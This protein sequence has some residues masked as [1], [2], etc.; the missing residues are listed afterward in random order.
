MVNKENVQDIYGLSAMQKGMLINYALDPSSV[1]YVEQFSFKIRGNVVPERM[2][3]ALKKVSQSYS[4]LRSIFSYKKTNQPRQVVLKKWDPQLIIKDFRNQENANEL[5]ETFKKEDKEKGFD[6]SK[7]VLI[8]GA[9][10][11]VEDQV[12]QFVL[13]F[14]HILMDGWSLSPI[15]RDII[16]YYSASSE[17]EIAK[18]RYPYKEYIRWYEKQ[19]TQEAADY[20]KKY[21]SDYEKSAVVPAL[22]DHTISGHDRHIFCLSS[23]I[24]EGMKELAKQM[25]VTIN[26]IFIVAWGILLQRYNYTTDVVF[27]NVVSGRPAELK[28]VESMVGVFINTQPVRVKTEEQDDFETLCQ[29][30]QE[31][32]TQAKPYE[33]YPLFEVQSQSKLKNKLINHVIA[34]ENYPLDEQLKLEGQKS[35]QELCFEEVEIFEQANYDFDVIVNP[36]ETFKVTFGY[37]SSKYTK[38]TMEYLERSLETIL[39]AVC[40][41]PH[42]LVNE[43]PVCS[44][45]DREKIIEHFNNRTYSYPKDDTVDGVFNKVVQEYKDKVAI[46]FN[47]ENITYGELDEWSNVIAK[48]LQENKVRTGDIVGLFMKR[49]P[50]MIATIIAIL[51]SGAAYMPLDI[52]NSKERLDFLIKD[53]GVKVICTTS[54]IDGDLLEVAANLILIDELERIQREEAKLA[55]HG[56]LDLAY[57]MYTSGSTGLPKGCCITHQNIL[58]LIFSEDYLPYGPEQ[59]ILLSSAIAFDGSTV[60]IWGALLHGSKLVLAN[61]GDQ[62]EVLDDKRLNRLIQEQGITCMALTTSLFNRISDQNPNTFENLRALIVAGDVLSVKHISRVKK[63]IPKLRLLNCYGPTENTTIS[64]THVIQMKDLDKDRIPIGKPLTNSMVY[65]VDQ[66]LNLLPVGAIGELCVAGDGVARGYHKRAELTEEKFLDNPYKEGT[67]LYRTGDLGCW[68]PDGTIDFLG[69]FDSQVKIRGYRV[70][71]GEIERVMS[72]LPGI[73]EVTVQV[74]E[75]NEDKQICAYYIPNQEVDIKVYRDMLGKKLPKYMVPTFFIALEKM[76]L[77]QNGKVDKKALPNPTYKPDKEEN[78]N[79]PLNAMEKIVKEIAIEVLGI[80]NVGVNDN[81]F[82]VG[83]NSLN[84][85]TINNRLQKKLDQ[86]IPLTALFEHT[87]VAS[88][89]E[90]LQSDEEVE[91]AKLE[92]EENES[93][94]M[95]NTLLRTTSLMM[96]LEEE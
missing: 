41:N 87:T 32:N 6:L 40:Q 37:E 80:E 53:G 5:V 23:E 66:Q 4:I 48:Q 63:A 2:A 33:Y 24:I 39:K 46:N 13:T 44:E 75:I 64:S 88:L 79:V 61:E 27:G 31:E 19:P 42:Q 56:P 72:D 76:P 78:Q 73:K 26:T 52:K 1:A 11:Q 28:G 84:L 35:G 96:Q 62:S 10:L 71:L 93:E 50:E 20:W 68:L 21:L 83:G 55:N 15:F 77:T 22:A 14:H 82:E 17:A 29:R 45:V 47:E 74:K 59:V 85:I 8:R 3:E 90:Y 86:D 58:R 36:G 67:R 94:D 81:F 12:W 16:S 92:E 65:V 70:E 89:A 34:F 49:S 60:E 25:H 43:I 69:R 7:D 18:E 57:L 30:V 91:M 9:L 54:D 95:K 51:K 38:E